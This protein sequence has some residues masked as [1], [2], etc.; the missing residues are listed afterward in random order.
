M[1]RAGTMRIVYSFSRTVQS[2]IP[3]VQSTQ[4]VLCNNVACQ[5]NSELFM[6]KNI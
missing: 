4:H 3:N 1:I 5:D 6:I 2:E